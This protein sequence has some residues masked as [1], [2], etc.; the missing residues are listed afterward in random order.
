MGYWRPVACGGGWSRASL[1]FVELLAPAVGEIFSP[2]Q[3][4][5]TRTYKHSPTHPHALSLI[6]C[7][8]L[9]P[10][11]QRSEAICTSLPAKLSYHDYTPT[12][13]APSLHSFTASL[14]GTIAVMSA[15]AA[16][17][18]EQVPSI[19]STL[20]LLFLDHLEQ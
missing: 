8:V 16:K 19:L 2:F 17:T 20:N 14:S 6:F 13:G 18:K 15:A 1:G 11:A 12:H 9:N 4:M 3:S 7:M 5:C 10:D